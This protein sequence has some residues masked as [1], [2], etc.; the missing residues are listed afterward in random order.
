MI[1]VPS[2]LLFQELLSKVTVPAS[3]PDLV[4]LAQQIANALSEIEAALSASQA[5][6]TA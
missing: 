5:E 3:H 4:A 6:Q 2:L 1:S